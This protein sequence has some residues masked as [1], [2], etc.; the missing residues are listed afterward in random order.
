[1]KATLNSRSTRADTLTCPKTWPIKNP[2]PN[3][4]TEKRWNKSA[5]RSSSNK[6]QPK[7][8]TKSTITS[9]ATNTY[10]SPPYRPLYRLSSRR[11]KISNHPETGSTTTARPFADLKDTADQKPT[12]RGRWGKRTEV[13]RPERSSSNQNTST[14]PTPPATQPYK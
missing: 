11:R 1:M 14:P 7:Q 5:N 4:K 3:S 2:M 12:T 9:T 8:A 13:G 10:P 6:N